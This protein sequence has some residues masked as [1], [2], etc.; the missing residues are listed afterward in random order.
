MS[1]VILK[2][3]KHQRI[4]SGHPWV[5]GNEIEMLHGAVE[6]GEIVEVYDAKNY[7]LG[8]GYYNERSQIRVRLL[9][10]ELDEE[11]N[12]EFFRRRI[13]SCWNYRKQLGYTENYRLVFGEADFLPALVIDKLGDFFV[14]QTL[15]LGMDRWKTTIVTVL[16]E[17]FSPKGIYERNDV[18]VRK[19]EGLSEQKNFLSA[20][21]PTKFKINEDGVKLSVDVENG[22]KTGFFLDQKDNR[23]ALQFISEGADVLDCFCYTGSFALF[24][25]KF[26]ARHVLGIDVSD[27]AVD[28]A[29]E[30][31]TLNNFA[32]ICEFQVANAFDELPKWAKEKKIFDLIILDPPAFTKNRAALE[33][34]SRG[35]KEINLR[36]MKLI[37]KGGFLVTFSC[38]HFMEPGLFFEM[39]QQAAYD[40]GKTIRQVAF[41]SQSKDHPIMWNIEETNYLK[42]FVLQVL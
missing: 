22:Q 13:I 3:G 5:Y 23:K 1:K 14:L 37:R 42:G 27:A 20:S 32:H 21:F 41:L 35:Y 10:R 38:S 7:F 2:K 15:S 9:T 24:A 19:L 25:A 6:P 36:A 30:N 39:I 17:L 28:Q 40:A 18:P 29:R 33:A 12:E 31:A 26:G 4:R 34:A 16:E 11:I 8:K